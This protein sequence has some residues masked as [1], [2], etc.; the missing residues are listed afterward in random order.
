MAITYQLEPRVITQE[1]QPWLDRFWVGEEWWSH[2]ITDFLRNQ[3]LEDSQ[4]GLSSTTL[5]SFP[6]LKDVVGF[7]TAA[8]ASLPTSQ[9]ATV[10]ALPP[11]FTAAR[12]PAVIIPYLGVGRQYRRIGHFGQ[13]IHLR[14]LEGLSA[15]PFAAVRLLYIECWAANEGGLAFWQKMGY[16]VFNQIVRPNPETDEPEYLNRLVYDRFAIQPSG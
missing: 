14:L 8:S 6:G 13:E 3:A 4:Q 10:V 7:I 16:T 5:F 9:I 11:S 1:D 2:E 15:A 12:V